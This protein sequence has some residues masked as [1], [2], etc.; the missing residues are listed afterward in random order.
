MLSDYNLKILSFSRT[1]WKRKFALPKQIFPP[2]FHIE[3]LHYL[4]VK[5]LNTSIGLVDD[6]I[7]KNLYF[8]QNFHILE[9]MANCFLMFY[10]QVH[11][12][13][14]NSRIFHEPFE[15]TQRSELPS[16]GTSHDFYSH[17]SCSLFICHKYFDT[18]ITAPHPANKGTGK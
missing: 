12:I 8:S 13:F 18:K 1:A 15:P 9:N 10:Y 5:A 3:K 6:H 17:F 11:T 7:W 16:I 14:I 4:L 2:N